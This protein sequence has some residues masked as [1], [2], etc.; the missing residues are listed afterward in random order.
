MSVANE[1]RQYLVFRADKALFGAFEAA[2]RTK[3]NGSLL[4]ATIDILRSLAGP[5][6]ASDFAKLEIASVPAAEFRS[7][8]L[9]SSSAA[10]ARDRINV[11]YRFENRADFDN[12][13]GFLDRL[14]RDGR[15]GPESALFNF[16]ADP[17]GFSI[18][19]AVPSPLPFFG[20][21]AMAR[22]RIKAHALAAL[23]LDGRGVNVVILD[24]GLNHAALEATHPGCWGGDLGLSGGLAGTAPRES[25]GMLVAR[26]VLDLAPRAIIY[27]LPIL[28]DH[29]VSPTVFASEVD[30]I[31][32]LAIR[33]IVQLR[34]DSGKVSPWVLVNAWAIF[35]RS[36]ERPLGDYTEDR[37]ESAGEGPDGEPTIVLGHPLNLLMG[38]AVENKID[39][40]FA[41]GNCGQFTREPRC[42]AFDRGARRSIWGANGHPDV[43]TVGAVS[44]SDM[45]MGYSS[46]GPLS[47]SDAKKPDICAPSQFREEHDAATVNT[48]T[49]TAASL[50]AGVIAA[51]RSNQV[52]DWGPTAITPA[53]LKLALRSTARGQGAAW[54][55]RTGHGI[56]DAAA[57][58]AALGGPQA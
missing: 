41:A 49:S 43:V 48:G 56:L 38:K 1:F 18:C 53:A 32:D 15:V 34:Q 13:R 40:V 3:D 16:G 55:G 6:V 21:R 26:N 39:V 23:G 2:A 58:T 31:F 5:A 54:N 57:L 12:F 36:K 33:K 24:R 10:V 51:V 7:V 9:T 37:H 35:D 27:D 28:P 4:K 46:Q 25:H 29:I 47:W 14:M 11:S 17:R 52:A 30:D 50:A 42:G 8:G 22:Q 20:T 44:A 45:W 19:D